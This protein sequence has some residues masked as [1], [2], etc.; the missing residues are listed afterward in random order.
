MYGL[1][2][3]AFIINAILAFVCGY[4]TL[5]HYLN[6]GKDF[7]KKTGLIGLISGAIGFVL[8]FLYVCYS[9]YI[10]NNDLAYFTPLFSSYSSL[11]KKLYPNGAKYKWDGNDYIEVYAN[12]KEDHAEYV[13]YKDLGKKQYNYD[14][15]YYEVFQKDDIPLLLHNQHCNIDDIY[16][17]IV[18]TTP[19]PKV[20]NDPNAED[21]EYL[22]P[23]PEESYINKYIHDRWLT[24]L[25]LAVII[26]ICDLTLAIFGLLLFL[27][28]GE[29]TP[30]SEQIPIIYKK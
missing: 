27:Q 9:G 30:S 3:S 10:F 25:I 7:E 13:K 16:S 26:F 15:K 23:K 8:T 1:E 18:G 14:T 28:K 4:L 21:C 22:F 19:R 20:S 2:H 17:F 11:L 12:D 29:Q 5:L 6:V 24:T